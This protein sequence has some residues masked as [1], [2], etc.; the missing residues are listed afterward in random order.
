MRDTEA[1]RTLRLSEKPRHRGTEVIKPNDLSAS[2]PRCVVPLGTLSASVS[3]LGVSVFPCS[4]T[5]VA[6]R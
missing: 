5:Q 1:R 3:F 2:V 4:S 6:S